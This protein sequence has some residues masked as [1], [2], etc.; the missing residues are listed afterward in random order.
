MLTTQSPQDFSEEPRDDERARIPIDPSIS[1]AADPTK[2]GSP[3][4]VGNLSIFGLGR[5]GPLVALLRWSS[6]AVG[7]VLLPISP[8]PITFNVLL[9]LLLLGANTVARTIRP[10]RL[11]PA[12]WRAEAAVLLDLAVAL[13]AVALTGDWASPFILCPLPTIILAAYGWGY[14][15]G[16]VAAFLTAAAITFFDII[17]GVSG[18][19]LRTG[20]FASMVAVS[21]ALVGGFTRQLWIDVEVRERRS[22]ATANRMVV[23]N[24][25]LHALHDIVQTLP[26]SLDLSEV[27]YSARDRFRELFHPDTIAILLPDETSTVWTVALADGTPMPDRLDQERLPGVLETACESR[28]FIHVGNEVTDA[29]ST[30]DPASTDAVAFPL[31]CQDRLVGIVSLEYRG[32][33]QFAADDIALIV[34]LAGALALA[35]ENAQCFSRLHALGAEAERARIA[36]ELHD[37]VAQSLAYVALELDRI[38]TARGDDELKEVHKVVRGVVSELRETLYELRATVTGE[39]GLGALAVSYVSRWA[40]KTNLQATYRDLSDGKRLPVQVEQE[41]WRI[42][43]E[44][45][46]NIERHADASH[47]NI[48]WEVSDRG[49][50]LEVEDDGRGMPSLGSPVGHYGLLGIRERADAIGARVAVNSQPTHGTAIVI[51][52]ELRQ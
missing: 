16:L 10:I 4:L 46:T 43:Q 47:V 37:R 51:E 21:A 11:Y 13:A 36:R 29:R 24:D 48:T 8:N 22:I 3:P 7:I 52:L 44:S 30:C 31:L 40:T 20:L 1:M 9:A 50:R 25:L 23:A 35:V 38:S 39:V 34:E 18:Q 19:S 26:A 17:S 32:T 33:K 28:S 14:R 41:I 42:L 6:L 45:L 2:S 5:L 27:L 15:K 49:A 12:T